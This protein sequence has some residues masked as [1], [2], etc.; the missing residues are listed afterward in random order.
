MKRIF[1]KETAEAIK[2]GFIDMFGKKLREKSDETKLPDD[3]A[4]KEIDEDESP[5]EDKAEDLNNVMTEHPMKEESNRD[6]KD[7]QSPS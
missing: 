2:W 6:K 4:K 1:S 7:E 3:E 5:R